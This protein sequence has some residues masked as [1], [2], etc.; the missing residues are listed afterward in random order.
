VKLDEALARLHDLDEIAVGVTDEGF[1]VLCPE[2]GQPELLAV[3]Y[4]VPD[5]AR[6]SRVVFPESATDDCPHDRVRSL[7]NGQDHVDLA[8]AFHRFIN[9]FDDGLWYL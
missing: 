3:Y 8:E 2:C 6:P 1:V 9:Q 7:A 4:D 5:D